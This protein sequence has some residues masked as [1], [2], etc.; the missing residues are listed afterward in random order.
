MKFDFRKLI[1]E[2]RKETPEQAQERR[3]N[4]IRMLRILAGSKDG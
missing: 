2:R 1:R 4:A 3:D